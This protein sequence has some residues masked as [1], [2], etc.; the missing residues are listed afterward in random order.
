MRQGDVLN[1]Y[2]ID[3]AP[4]NA[5]GGMSQWAFGSKEGGEYFVKMFLSPKY[6]TDDGPG[7]EEAKSRKR[8]VCHTFERR[9]V[10][11]ARRLDPSK[12]GA[13]NLVVPCDFFRVESTYVKVMPRVRAATLPDAHRL[14]GYQILVLLRSLAFSLRMLHSEG[15][16]HGDIKPDNVMV[17]QPNAELFVSKLID[18]DEAYVVGEPPLPEHIVGDPIYYSPELLRY[19][20]RDERLPEDAL[21]PASD[22]FSLGLFLHHFLTG[23]IPGFDR[24]RANYPAEAILARNPL[25]IASV[26]TVMQPMIARML[27]LVPDRRPDIEEF[28]QFLADV[29]QDALVP[30]PI[31][32]APPARPAAP[33]A[34]SAPA[35]PSSPARPAPAAPAPTAAPSTHP[36]AP[37]TPAP[38][39]PAAGGLRSTMGRRRPPT[40]DPTPESKDPR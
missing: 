23:R 12:P 5:G 20:K 1:G 9:H 29:D 24:S 27:A 40:G 18:F 2:R 38:A 36:P 21:G 14:S 22:M 37:A 17:E 16:V 32:V 13:G 4:T 34:P 33:T 3:T 31:P 15:V 10:E 7:S 8:A 39:T 30:P 26:P 11:I 25:E 35:S 28:I 6:P 19:I